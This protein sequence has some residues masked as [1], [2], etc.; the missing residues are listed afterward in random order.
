MNGLTSWAARA[1]AA[2]AGRAE[3]LGRRLEQMSRRLR[4]VLSRLAGKAAAGAVRDAVRDALGLPPAPPAQRRGARAWLG[5]YPGCADPYRRAGGYGGY[6]DDRE[7]L[8]PDRADRWPYGDPEGDEYRRDDEPP[9]EPQ[10]PESW[11]A[12]LRRALGV[13]WQVLCAR[14]LLRPTLAAVP[15]A[16]W[17][18]LAA[19]AAA[20]AGGRA[21]A[22]GVGL[23]GS[24][25]ALTDLA[26][27]ARDAP[28]LRP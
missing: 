6:A 1:R 27:A 18:G 25:L 23:A 28:D 7:D 3:R 19:A 2:L 5:G 13:G 8:D 15:A 22:A 4:D 11:A 24:A 12:R 21:V 9:A 17:L 26:A 16:L 14:L 20:F 10:V